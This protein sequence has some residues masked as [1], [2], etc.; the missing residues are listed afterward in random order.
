MDVEMVEMVD[1]TFYSILISILNKQR[2]CQILI[3][4][5]LKKNR[6]YVEK[7]GTEN[8]QAQGMPK[9][10]VEVI[11]GVGVGIQLLAWLAGWVNGW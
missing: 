4:S 1:C 6:K 3:I 7:A 8:S 5:L 10:I 11:V 2:E 9:V